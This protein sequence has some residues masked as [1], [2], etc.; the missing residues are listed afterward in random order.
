M[1]R[2]DSLWI[3]CQILLAWFLLLFPIPIIVTK[4]LVEYFF[5]EESLKYLSSGVVI[6]VWLFCSISALVLTIILIPDSKEE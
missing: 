3:A 5:P 4:W 2:N 1:S 6:P